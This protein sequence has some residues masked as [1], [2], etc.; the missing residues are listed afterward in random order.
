MRLPKP[1]QVDRQQRLFD[2]DKML[3][4]AGEA[5]W[6]TGEFFEQA[7]ADVSGGV[8]LRTDSRCDI[9]PDIQLRKDLF[10]ESKGCGRNAA[11]IF[12]EC[13]LKKDQDFMR[14]TGKRIVYW[15]WHHTYKVSDAESYNTLRD[16]LAQKTR[17][18]YIVD[19][20]L[21][22]KAVEGK[23]V[24][25]VNSGYTRDGQRLGY[26]QREYG[27]GWTLRLSFFRENSDPML[28]AL[29][30][31]VFGKHQMRGVQVWA[32]DP[33]FEQFVRRPKNQLRLDFGST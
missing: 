30:L 3:M 8:R 10:F 7:A 22:A 5:R 16:S 31:Q 1:K 6:A 9:C 23:P 15:F 2:P 32:S 33:E 25:T 12:Y 19:A 14:Q 4:S 28:E 17:N 20:G 24:R 27:T 13:R 21:L 18:L 26:G 29:N 11:V